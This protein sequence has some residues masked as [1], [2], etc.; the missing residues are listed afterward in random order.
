[1]SGMGY[2]GSLLKRRFFF[3]QAEDGI[4]GT[5]VTGVQTCALPIFDQ[6]NYGLLVL[7]SLTM[8]ALQGDGIY[9]LQPT[10]TIVEGSVLDRLTLDTVK[11][12][13]VE[14]LHKIGRASCRE[15]AYSSMSTELYEQRKQKTG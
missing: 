2:C 4:R 9:T 13:L 1:M 11:L 12:S 10:R 14:D 6:D 3:F 7:D 15:R 5:S 8:L